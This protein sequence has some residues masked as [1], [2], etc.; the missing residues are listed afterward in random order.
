[1]YKN[2]DTMWRPSC[3]RPHRQAALSAKQSQNV[4]PRVK[5]K[6]INVFE[7]AR[8]I[9]LVVAVVVSLTYVVLAYYARPVSDGLYYSID[10]DTGVPRLVDMCGS[11][12]MTKYIDRHQEKIS[13]VVLCFPFKLIS[14]SLP[15]AKGNISD[16]DKWW[17]KAPEVHAYDSPNKYAASFTLPQS[18]EADINAKLREENIAHW[19]TVASTLVVGLIVWYAIVYI[20]GWIM[21]GFLGIPR[22]HD[23]REAS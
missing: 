18:A 16:A 8:R 23:H 21:R 11:T 20:I 22:G 4:E 17:A 6:G 12:D 2:N 1:M 15:A 19:E 13:F 9:A 5:M 3:Q 14:E 10:A 7:G